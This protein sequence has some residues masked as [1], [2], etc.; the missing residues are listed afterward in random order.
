[1]DLVFSVHNRTYWKSR[2]EILY[3][4]NF[5]ELWFDFSKIGDKSIVS[6]PTKCCLKRL[7]DKRMAGLEEEYNK[8][9]LKFYGR[10]V[11]KFRIK[12]GKAG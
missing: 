11:S 2:G 10:K 3:K 5:I 12:G 1:M 4:T 9:Y 6:V 7:K 8:S